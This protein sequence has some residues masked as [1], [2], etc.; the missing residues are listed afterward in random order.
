VCR[1]SLFQQNRFNGTIPDSIALLPAVFQIDLEN[2]T[3]TGAVPAAFWANPSL[4]SLYANTCDARGAQ[5]TLTWRSCTRT[6]ACTHAHMHAP[7]CCCGRSLK[8]NRLT[9]LDVLGKNGTC[10]ATTV[11]VGPTAGPGQPQYVADG[12]LYYFPNKSISIGNITACAADAAN[13]GQRTN[14]DPN[15]EEPWAFTLSAERACD[16]NVSLTVIQAWPP[17]YH[18]RSGHQPARSLQAPLLAVRYN[19]CMYMHKCICIYAYV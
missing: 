13:P 10:C 6:R 2:N 16:G 11:H 12:L 19:M 7:I 18:R 15:G 17:L 5:R 4:T 8:G 14:T 9:S 1:C 3:L